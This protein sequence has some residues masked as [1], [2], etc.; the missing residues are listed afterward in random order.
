MIYI[1]LL[2][3]LALVSGEDR[4][5]KITDLEKCEAAKLCLVKDDVC[6]TEDEKERKM[7][8][9]RKK[10]VQAGFEE[11]EKQDVSLMSFD[12]LKT[13]IK[14]MKQMTKLYKQ[15]KGAEGNKEEGDKKNYGYYG[16]GYGYITSWFLGY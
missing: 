11:Q 16:L 4:C 1:S 5:T 6:V 10:L 9:W 14:F 12:E 8:K 15:K 3:F 13:T 7:R 2:A